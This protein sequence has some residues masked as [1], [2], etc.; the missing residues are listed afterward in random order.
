[1]KDLKNK[2]I[3]TKAIHGGVIKNKYGALATPIRLQLLYLKM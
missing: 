1:M 2:G 3:G